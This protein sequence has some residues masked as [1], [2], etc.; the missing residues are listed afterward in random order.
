LPAKPG[1]GASTIAVN[2]SSI[3][4]RL[5]GRKTL[6][7]DLDLKNGVSSFLL[8]LN[9]PNSIESALDYASQMDASLWADLTT[10]RGNL[11]ILGSGSSR[12][13]GDIVTGQL[14]QLL[15]YIRRCYSAVCVDLS[16]NMEDFTDDLL[17]D[18][19]QI[20][21]VCTQDISGLHL[22]RS[23]AETL[24]AMNLGDKVS[25][26]LNRV[27]KRSGFSIQEIEKLVGFRVRFSCV[28]DDK[29]ILDAVTAGT[30]V[31]PAC[32]LGKQFEAIAS[33]MLGASGAQAAKSPPQRRFVEYF[34]ITPQTFSFAPRKSE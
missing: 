28:S 6:L 7:M 21:L 16:G 15:G 4:A 25:I 11:D 8:K 22:A 13:R 32:E 27:E 23:K 30:Q 19:K 3:L 12:S 18:A 5:S 34:A 17:V 29:R 14:L 24:R 9:N 20:F 1:G 10:V 31:D 2:T 33:Y 26:L